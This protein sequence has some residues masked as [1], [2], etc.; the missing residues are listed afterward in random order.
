VHRPEKPVAGKEELL[1]VERQKSITHPMRFI[2]AMCA[3]AIPSSDP[4]IRRPGD[5][6]SMD[7]AVKGE[8]HFG[9]YGSLR[10][11]EPGDVK[12]SLLESET[13]LVGFV[14]FLY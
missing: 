6:G 8:L 13:S 7:R 3:E 10:R 4:Q 9:G 2:K 1:N 5:M 12:V 14:S 11:P